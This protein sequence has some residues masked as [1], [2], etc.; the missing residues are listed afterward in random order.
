M[1]TQVKTGLLYSGNFEP[2]SVSGLVVSHGG[3]LVAGNGAAKETVAGTVSVPDNSTWTVYASLTTGL[4]VAAAT[5]AVPATNALPLWRGV[6][7]SGSTTLQDIRSWASSMIQLSPAA[8][9]FREYL[10]DEFNLVHIW[11]MDETSG[12]SCADTGTGTNANMSHSAPT[13]ITVGQTGDVGYET[14]NAYTIANAGQIVDAAAPSILHTSGHIGFVFKSGAAWA[15]D[16]LFTSGSSSTSE[17]MFF[18]PSTLGR[19]TFQFAS[20]SNS[21]N[22]VTT[23]IGDD[24]LDD[25]YHLVVVAQPGDTTGV[26][27]YID[28]ALMVNGTET[29]NGTSDADSWFHDAPS[30]GRFAIASAAALG[31]NIWDGEIAKVWISDDV[32]TDGQMTVLNDAR[33]GLVV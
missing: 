1:V 28:G 17:F 6:S 32:P 5:S 7:N 20:V 11:E 24:L 3:G 22:V 9:G 21:V 16:I 4:L 23:N 15:N 27:I 2:R 31:N 33:T 10:S 18:A 25:V 30:A 14:D 13:G 8:R 12:N 26:N 19:M 29:Y